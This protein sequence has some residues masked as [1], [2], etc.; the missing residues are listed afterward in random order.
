M[1][2][3]LVCRIHEENSRLRVLCPSIGF[4]KLSVKN[5][6][7]IDRERCIGK[8]VRLGQ[9][10]ELY[11][12]KE[13]SGRVLL[14]SIVPSVGYGDEM[15]QVEVL[16]KKAEK[17]IPEKNDSLSIDAPMDGMFYLCAAPGSPT[18]VK[19]GDMVRPQQVV[20]LIEVMKC[21][22]PMKYEGAGDVKIEKILL[23]NGSPIQSGT[24]IYLIS[25]AKN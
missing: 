3:Q 7:F 9:S 11:L 22:Y 23:G 8:L 20:G 17:L 15:F 13:I 18:F 2:K 19:V 4:L 10:F 14:E 24:K 1:S 6:E 16:D 12:P 25:S 5:G 21:F